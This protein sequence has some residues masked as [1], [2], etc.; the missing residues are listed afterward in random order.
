[1]ADAKKPAKKGEE[2]EAVY[3]KRSHYKVE[4]GR[5]VRGRRFCPKDGPGVFLAD[6]KDRWSCGKCGYV[7]FKAKKEA[8]PA[9]A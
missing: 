1:M 7:E 8:P 9:R 3:N 2:K 4:G 5:V 6:H